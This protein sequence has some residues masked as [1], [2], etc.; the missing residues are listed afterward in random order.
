MQLTTA[1][2][3]E[4]LIDNLMEDMLAFGMRYEVAERVAPLL[5]PLFDQEGVLNETGAF[6]EELRKQ[7][8]RLAEK[9]GL[10]RRH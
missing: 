4:E 7:S 1:Q 5:W 2:R 8:P 3:I 10:A 6:A 9:L